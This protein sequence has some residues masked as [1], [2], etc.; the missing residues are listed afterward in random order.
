MVV[1]NSFKRSL[2]ELRNIRCLAVVGVF[3]AIFV[4]LDGFCSV[5]I[6]DFLKINFAYLALAVIGMLFG[7]TVGL[8]SGFA[9]DLVGYFVNPVGAFIPWFAL[10]TALE[11][12]IYGLFLYDFVPCK[13]DGS[14][15]FKQYMAQYGK[16]FFARAI[17][18][19]I[20]NLLLNT[21]ALY[22]CGFIGNT[23]EGFWTLVGARIG[24]NAVGLAIAFVIMPM[25]LAPV[26][27]AYGKFLSGGRAR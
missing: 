24:T 21:L 1:F 5:R 19:L 11:G 20:C 13:I 4:V 8:I 17:V 23:G 16:L 2:G 9:C 14:K 26:R 10:I 15:S 27:I 6:G 18:V 7:P 12:M 3:I 22:S 25:V